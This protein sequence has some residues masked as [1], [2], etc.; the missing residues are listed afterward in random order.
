MAYLQA[1]LLADD[2]PADAQ[3]VALHLQDALSELFKA[4]VELGLRHSEVGKSFGE[5][6]ARRER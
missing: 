1:T 5:F 6:L 3:V 4:T 2:L